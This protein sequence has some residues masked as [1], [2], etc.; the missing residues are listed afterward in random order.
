[1]LNRHELA[2][3]GFTHLRN[4]AL[5]FQ[6]RL[7]GLIEFLFEDDLVCG[8]RVYWPNLQGAEF[9]RTSKGC[10]AIN[11]W[12][13][14]QGGLSIDVGL[15][16]SSPGPFSPLVENGREPAYAPAPGRT[17]RPHWPSDLKPVTLQ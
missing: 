6:F 11:L 2:R 3:A 15:Y 16:A 12:P 1:M 8:F 4:I 17:I 14:L 7:K 10:H 5:P 13:E 9:T